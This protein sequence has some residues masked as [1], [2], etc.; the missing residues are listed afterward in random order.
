MKFLQRFYMGI[1]FF[2]LYAPI[3]ILMIFSFNDSKNRSVWEGFTF[4]WYK[5]LFQDEQILHALMVTLAVAVLSALIS[6]VL[7]TAAAI[8]I[9]NM[10]KAPK[11]AY[12][13]VNNIPVMN[14]DIITGV[15]ML[16]LFVFLAQT[17]RIGI[18]QL[19]FFTLLLAHVTFNTP[20]VILS[21]MP[22][23]RQMDPNIY[24]AALDL[25]AT[26]REAITKVMLPQIM[27]GVVTGGIMAFTM[28][29]DD[30]VV[31]YFT[32]GST[33]QTL[34]AYIFAMTKKQVSPEINALST[35]LF[36]VVLTLLLVVNVRQEKD[37]RKQ[38]A[39]GKR[40]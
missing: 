4:R 28:S 30:V 38:D 21:V 10:K 5:E 29:L 33:S 19:S 8:G 36:L 27:P 24:E 37:R 13:T 25:G 2:F 11:A 7:G 1:I 31:S 35:I 12:L 22:K 26:P 14:P 16:L 34:G 6:T 9:N 3:V 23:L 15:S 32:S 39:M 20:Y 18:F 40:Y 17:A